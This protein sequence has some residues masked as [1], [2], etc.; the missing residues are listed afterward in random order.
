MSHPA[1]TLRSRSALLAG[2]LALSLSL[3][4]APAV[5]AQDDGPDA[6]VRNLM[7]AI[8]AKDFEALPSFFCAEYADEAGGFNLEAIAGQMPEGM[9]ATALF[10]AFEFTPDVQSVE[11]L[12][13]TED[14]AVVKLVA[15]LSMSVNAEALG[16]FIASL[17]AASGLAGSPGA[18]ATPDPAMIEMMTAMIAQEFA[19]ETTQIDEEITLVP[20][21]AMPWVVCDQLTGGAEASMLPAASPEASPAA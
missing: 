3:I 2:S 11:V 16:P 14:E 17:L 10:D 19:A 4:A 6:T 21:E 8:Q 20:G 9:D 1:P 13:Q 18:D 7:A 15:S 12:S 5:M